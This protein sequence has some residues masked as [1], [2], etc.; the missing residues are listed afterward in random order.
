MYPK[1]TIIIIQIFLG[2]FAAIAFIIGFGFFTFFLT[3]YIAAIGFIFSAFLTLIGVHLN[4]LIFRRQLFEWYDP[5]SQ[6]SIKFFSLITASTS[7]VVFGYSLARAIV[8]HDDWHLLDSWYVSAGS[9]LICFILSCWLYGL[10]RW[11]KRFIELCDPSL[12]EPI[13]RRT[14]RYYS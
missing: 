1:L 5:S 9:A 13:R 14:Y 12:V 4:V 8:H 6:E 2:L 11:T 7:I 10:T 3:N